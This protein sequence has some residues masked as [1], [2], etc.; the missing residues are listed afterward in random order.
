MLFF[1][2]K[3][4]TM[5][6][7]TINSN[8]KAIDIR[9]VV[10]ERNAKVAKQLPTFIYRWLE[11]ILHVKEINSFMHQS[12]H[13]E[14]I[15]FAN[16]IIDYTNIS[17]D[18]TGI[19]NIPKDQRFMFVSNHPLGGLDGVILLKI[20]N[21][22]IGNTRVLINDFLLA[23]TPFGRWFVPVNKIGGQ[24][25]SS[26]QVVEELYQSNDHVLIFPA[27]LCSRKIKGEIIDLEWQKHFIQKS[28]QHKL[29]VVPIYFSGKNSRKFYNLA[30]L[31]K[32]FRIKFNIE[33]MYLVDEL[34]KH[35]NKK[36]SLHFGKPIPH[37]TFDRSKKPKA[38]ANEVKDIVYDLRETAH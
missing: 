22:N 23:I 19:E 9:D 24:A 5:E 29:D 18:V 7:D 16:A 25:R 32:L 20:L 36:F 2:A 26:I 10:A 35:K 31:R 11:R 38:W 12:G 34:Y 21:E 4:F 15:N 6:G 30:K 37:T 1:D 13:L 3:I 14:G 8:F 33:M 17:F 27:G 28:K